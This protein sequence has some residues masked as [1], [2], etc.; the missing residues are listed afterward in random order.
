MTTRMETAR[1]LT[2]QEID[3]VAGGTRGSLSPPP[4]GSLTVSKSSGP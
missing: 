2:G 4:S 1:G 3:Y